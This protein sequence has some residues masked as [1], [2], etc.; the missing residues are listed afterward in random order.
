[1]GLIARNVRL[2]IDGDVLGI[3]DENIRAITAAVIIVR[4]LENLVGLGP[5]A[6]PSVVASGLGVANAA[7]R[8]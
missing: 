5:A 1:M 8:A 7:D 3:L 6:S 2:A 4:V